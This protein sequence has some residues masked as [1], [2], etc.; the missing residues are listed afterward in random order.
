MRSVDTGSADCER[1]LALLDAYLSNELTAE[2]TAHISCHIGRCP[3]CGKE[4]LVR[5]QIKRLLQF[6]VSR[7]GVPTGLRRKV[8]RMVRGGGFGFSRLFE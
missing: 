7:S 1:A 8:S 3:G 4:F 5:E 6:T 2:T